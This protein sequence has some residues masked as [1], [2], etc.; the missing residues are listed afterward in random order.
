MKDIDKEINKLLAIK[1]EVLEIQMAIKQ[2]KIAIIPISQWKYYELASNDMLRHD[3][4][5]YIVEPEVGQYI[6]SYIY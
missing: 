5:Y 6:E 4:L 1:N 3:T 2:S